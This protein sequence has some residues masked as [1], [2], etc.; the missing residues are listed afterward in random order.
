[1]IAPHQVSS[2]I[3]SPVKDCKRPEDRVV[4]D[5]QYFHIF[6]IEVYYSKFSLVFPCFYLFFFHVT[7]L[8]Y[9]EKM[10]LNGDVY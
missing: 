9:K 5:F 6:I 8:A 7:Q 1:M 2:T 10:S 3:F 4:Q